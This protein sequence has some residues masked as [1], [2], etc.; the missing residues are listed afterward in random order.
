MK[1][2][3]VYDIAKE[4][5]VSV[6][7][8]SRVLNNTAPVKKETRERINELINKYQFQPNALARS[9]TKKETGMIGIILP[10]ITN[11]FFPEVLSGFDR[12]ARKQGY[13]YFLCD[14]VSANG[15][16]ADQYVRESQYLNVL[17][18]KQVDGIVMLGGRIDLAKPGKELTEEVVEVGKRLPLL[19]INGRL[20]GS[21]LSRVAADERLGA[22]L[23]TRHLIGLG[24]RDIAVVGG[25]R[26]M[27]NTLQ[28]IAGFTKTMERHGIP[29]RR[30]WMLHE[31]FS[32]A[33]GTAFMD[34]LLSLPQRPT[35][36]FCLNDL[37]AIGALKAAAKAGLKV[38]GD[39]SIVGYD[40]IPFASNS[41]PELTTVSLRANE[42]GR[43]AAEI[44]HKMITKDK[45]AKTTLLKP[46]L[47]VREST[48][49]P[50]E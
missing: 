3:T 8:V 1:P 20:P 13:T 45:V 48:A 28:R 30:E 33:S 25:Y 2:V 41:I 19:L 36:I 18:E 35:A 11:P 17:T 27:S 42:L 34:R 22:E 39:I 9:L 43:T 46:E 4:A 7:T 40:D 32:V 10:D 16:S 38:P 49:A 24:H 5:N 6:A 14:T 29:V 15:D 31:G 23:A 47:V 26:H 44:L 21:S 37:V 50:A 12:E